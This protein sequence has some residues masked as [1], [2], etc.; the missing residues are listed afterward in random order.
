MTTKI[1]SMLMLA[2]L[3]MTVGCG[4]T[5]VDAGN[6][7]IEVNSC[8]GGGVQDTPVSV[9]YHFTGPC[10]DIAEYATFQQTLVLAHDKETAINVTSSEGLP[11]SMDV[12]LSFTMDPAK[13]PSIYKKYRKDL[14][15]IQNVFFRQTIREALQETAAQY[16]AQ[17]LYSDKKE[18]A[19]AEVQGQLTKKLGSDGFNVTQFTIN[20]TRVPAEVA[21]AIKAK[22]AMV[23]EAQRAEQQ[24]K[25]T[26]AEAQQRIA[27]AEGEAAAQRLKADAEAYSNQKL[28]SSLSPVLVE[29]L[30]VQKWN[31][32]LP[33]VQGGS[34][35]LFN[36]GSK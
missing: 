30:R 10:T 33:Q 34:G 23:Q 25:K 28:A 35:T 7:G 17:Q 1:C 27:A 26:Q 36:L 14:T 15:D 4:I 9:G 24:V 3:T 5:H 31:G 13:A 21:G 8:S 12:S 19:R 6:V 22:V 2:L 29:Y 32:Q 18:S 11:I 16:T 20:E